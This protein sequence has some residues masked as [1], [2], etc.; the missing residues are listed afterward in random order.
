MNRRPH[1]GLAQTRSTD[2]RLAASWQVVEQNRARLALP[3]GARAGM[4]LNG[5]AQNS[6]IR[7][8]RCRLASPQQ[9][10]LQ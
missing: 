2:R 1:T 10:C 5:V 4:T 9:L 8:I 6:Q 7:S 3:P